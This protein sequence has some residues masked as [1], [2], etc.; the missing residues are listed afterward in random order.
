MK[1]KNKR[2]LV[3]GL[4]ISGISTVKA[5]DILGAKIII[6]DSKSEFELKD[7]LLEIGEK[8]AELYLEGKNPP[9]ENIDLIIKKN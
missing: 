7:A 5:L 8:N 1:I 3:L 2:I 6:S 9:L 4:G